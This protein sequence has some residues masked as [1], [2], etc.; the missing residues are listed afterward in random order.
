VRARHGTRI[1][2]PPHAISRRRGLRGRDTFPYAITFWGVASDV[3]LVLVS[4]HHLMLVVLVL[5]VICLLSNVICI[6]IYMYR[7]R[8]T[9]IYLDRLYRQKWVVHV[10]G[11]WALGSIIIFCRERERECVCV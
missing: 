3:M 6:H 2:A 5:V 11:H 10:G 1:T 8:H 9:H 4:L 7:Y